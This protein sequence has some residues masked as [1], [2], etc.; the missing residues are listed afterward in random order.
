MCAAVGIRRPPADSRRVAG[1]RSRWP[2]FCSVVLVLL[3]IPV[4]G[5]P[6]MRSDNMTVLDRNYP[7]GLCDFA[8][9]GVGR[10]CRSI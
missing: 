4:Y 7:M 8:R 2:H 5:K 10:A 1:R 9:S 6:G 3:A